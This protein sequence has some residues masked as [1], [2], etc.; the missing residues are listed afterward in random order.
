VGITPIS[1]RHHIARLEA[2]G[3]VSVDEERHG[4]GRPRMVYSLTESGLERFPTRYVR[5]TLRLLE[6]L[7]ETMPSSIVNK[8]FTQMAQDLADELGTQADIENLSLEE[9]LEKMCDFLEGEGFT[10]N[11][12]RQ[13]DQ[14]LI[15]EVNCP[16][17]HVGQS[18]PEVC[19]VDQTLISTALSIPAEKVQCILNG[20]SV[21][22]YVI[23]TKPQET[24]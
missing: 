20:D 8:L 13:G 21:C 4:V 11:W 6:Q 5:L 7:K 3:L 23:S 1:M 22:T 18:H 10:I 2:D 19:A 14:Y 12:K 16:Y 15:Q 24:T 17:L 9:R